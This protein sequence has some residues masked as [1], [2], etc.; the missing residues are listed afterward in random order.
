MSNF[1]ITGSIT[2]GGTYNGV[3]LNN[4]VWTIYTPTVIA[5]TGTFTSV[6]GAGRYKQ[7]G[8]TVFLNVI[9]TITTNG[10]AANNVQFTLPVN[11]VNGTGLSPA[12]NGRA[13]VSGK[14]LQGIVFSATQGLVLNYDNSY[15][16][17]DGEALNISGV[18]EAA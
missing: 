12:L 6:A 3:T 18:Y 4:N 9:I 10:S 14:Q 7:I 13:S 5:Q 16:G 1:T 8:K 2:I 15:P 17:A 11:A